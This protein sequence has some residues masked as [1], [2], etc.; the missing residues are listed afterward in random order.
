MRKMILIPLFI[1]QTLFLFSQ[2]AQIK[3]EQ[4]QHL[5][6]PSFEIRNGCPRAAGEFN[7]CQTWYCPW[8]RESPDY[9]CTDC[10]SISNNIVLD[11]LDAMDGNCFV[12]II[13][14]YWKYYSAQEHIQT[15]LTSPLEKGNK[16]KLSFYLRTGEGSSYFTDRIAVA[17]TADSLESFTMIKKKR[18]YMIDCKEAKLIK[19]KRFFSKDFKWQKV[20]LEFVA[21]GDESFLTVG[22]FANNLLGYKRERIYRTLLGDSSKVGYYD[23]DMF[24]LIKVD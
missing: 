24:E 8:V 19:E 15:K 11:S 16:Y 10:D 12:R 20:E 2:K 21:K 3:D 18:Y 14:R 1:A 13:T 6:N 17:F 7:L 22:I 23:L 9:F 4:N 5:F